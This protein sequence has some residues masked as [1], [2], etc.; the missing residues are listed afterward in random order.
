MCT[1]LHLFLFEVIGGKKRRGRP[2][3]L[4]AIFVFFSTSDKGSPTI[5]FH[6]FFG[7]R[8]STFWY[9]FFFV[10]PFAM[11]NGL[12]KD[13]LAIAIRSLKDRCVTIAS[14]TKVLV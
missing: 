9:L 14:L 13:R 3:I 11:N 8:I 7:H 6:V 10:L 1:Y 12:T 5:C 4:P 2:G